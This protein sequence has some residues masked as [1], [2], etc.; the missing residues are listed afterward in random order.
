MNR[1][2]FLTTATAA[3]ATL[4]LAG[5]NDSNRQAIDYSK[6]PHKQDKNKK[7]FNINRGKKTVLKLATSWPAHYP[8]IGTGVEKFAKRVKDISGDSL[9]IKL[10]PKSV[11]LSTPSMD[12]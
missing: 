2:D 6:H 5:C 3:S 8:I 12:S 9:E 10:Y 7:H 4:A 1:R 11:A